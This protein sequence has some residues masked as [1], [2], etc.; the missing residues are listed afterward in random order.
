MS[1]SVTTKNSKQKDV[2]WQKYLLCMALAEYQILRGTHVLIWETES[3]KDLVAEKSTIPSENKS[4]SMDP[5][6]KQ[7]TEVDLS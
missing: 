4:L 7:E 3:G 6:A 2:T 1:P 5:S